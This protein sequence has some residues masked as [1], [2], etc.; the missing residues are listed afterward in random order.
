MAARV[1]TI[2]GAAAIWLLAADFLWR[3][4]VPAG[5]HLP[6]LDP[7]HYF[8]SAA[9]SRTLRYER[10]QQIDWLLSVFATLSALVVVARRG[11]RLGREIGLG[12]VGTGVVLGML[13]ITT[14]WAVNLPFAIASRWW[15]RRHGLAH[16]GWI[17]WLVSPWAQLVV[18]V[19]IALLTI[20][21]VLVLAGRFR[22]RWWIAAAPA[23]TAIALL[24]AFT[25]PYV[26]T[27]GTHGLRS[28]ALRSAAQT[29]ERREGVTGT[30]ISVQD[31]SETTTQA[32]AM[33]EG[34]GPSRR[35]VLW[36][37]L[38]DGRFG[39]REVRFVIAHELAHTARRHIWKGVAWFGLLA[40][41]GA[42]VIAEVTRRRG[43]LRDPG[44]LPLAMLV[45]AVFQLATTPLVNAISRR[46]EAEA[47]W[48]ALETTREP[49]A[50]RGLF[51][52]F[53]RTSLQQPS[54]PRW[55]YVMLE[56]HPTIIQRIAMAEAWKARSRRSAAALPAGS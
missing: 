24:F 34:I 27:L 45:L 26:D 25:A 23:F 50:A 38:L 35:V 52:G 4:K 9:L 2:T 46:Y 44:L 21:L 20:V 42:F 39:F 54:P 49:G 37:T 47:D 41:P 1:A 3:T 33:S 48:I 6:H 28:A 30:P 31:V 14:V 29:L 17:E 18:R 56:D 32:N 11:P 12:R 15:E 43:G 55:D 5:L 36:N 16:G 22:R 8:S 51:E 13:T 10:F 7:A 40:L 53:S 19:V